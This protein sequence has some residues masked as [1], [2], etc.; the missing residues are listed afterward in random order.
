MRLS[1]HKVAESYLKKIAICIQNSE[2]SMENIIEK[3]I[4]EFISVTSSL[5][6]M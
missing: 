5:D 6:N 1:K 3:S 4:T 2:S